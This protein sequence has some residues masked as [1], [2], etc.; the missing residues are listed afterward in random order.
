METWIIPILG[1]QKQLTLR[2]RRIFLML[3]RRA[4]AVKV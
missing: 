1:E 2:S 3:L 4:N